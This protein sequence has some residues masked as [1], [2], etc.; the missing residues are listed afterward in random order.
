MMEDPLDHSPLNW[1]VSMAL[2]RYLKYESGDRAS[3][4]GNGLHLN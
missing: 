3:I 4:N 1:D 2:F